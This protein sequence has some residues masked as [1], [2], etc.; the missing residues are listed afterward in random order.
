[1]SYF[2]P[3]IKALLTENKTLLLLLDLPGI[4]N[5]RGQGDVQALLYLAALC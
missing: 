4:V 5:F 3:L 2:F 1:M